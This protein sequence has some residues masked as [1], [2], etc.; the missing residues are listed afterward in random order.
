MDTPATCA[1]FSPSPDDSPFLKR[2]RAKAAKGFKHTK[3]TSLENATLLA[4]WLF[5]L[6]RADEALDVCRFVGQAEFNGN[7]NLWSWVEVALALQ[8]RLLKSKDKKQAKQCLDRIEAAGYVDSRLSGS[9]LDRDTVRDAI[10]DQDKS[11]ER[12]ARLVNVFELCFIAAL[13][14]SKKIPVKAAE[15]EMADHIARLRE[16]VG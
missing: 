12:D 14:G 3:A 10:R 2:I 8:S 5:A 6:D 7:F 11:L 16:L 9:L 15:K 4:F 13:G 1:A